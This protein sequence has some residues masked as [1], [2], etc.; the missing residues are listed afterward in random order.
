MMN[1]SLLSHFSSCAIHVV[2][3]YLYKT[4]KS[5]SFAANLKLINKEN[6]E[7]G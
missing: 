6:I 2:V 1:T 7:H 3:I 4:E 5:G